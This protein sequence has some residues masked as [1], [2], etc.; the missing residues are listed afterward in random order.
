[1]AVLNACGA[2]NFGERWRDVLVS[3]LPGFRVLILLNLKKKEKSPTR[4]SIK[5]RT[6]NK[7]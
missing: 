6:A 5:N 3:L 1:M 7:S 4:K 2:S